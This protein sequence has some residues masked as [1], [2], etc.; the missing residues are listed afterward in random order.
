MPLITISSVAWLYS[1]RLSCTERKF[2]DKPTC[3]KRLAL[4]NN[5]SQNWWSVGIY[6][7]VHPR[8][9]RLESDSK[10]C[11]DTEMICSYAQCAPD[12]PPWAMTS[13]W[14][15]TTAA[16]SAATTVTAASSAF[17]SPSLTFTHLHSP[18]LTFT[19][20]H[21]PSLTFTHLH[22]PSLTFKDASTTL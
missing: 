3:L 18:S 22:S 12:L 16:F 13:A 1:S 9:E 14:C 15:S 6:C 7:I 17:Q 10:R 8:C 11:F 21:S 2:S 20:L 4:P 19:H 5:V